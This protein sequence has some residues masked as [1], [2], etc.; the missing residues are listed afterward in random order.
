MAT[1]NAVGKVSMVAKKALDDGGTRYTIKVQ[2]GVEWT[3]FLDDRQLDDLGAELP[4]RG[5]ALEVEGTANIRVNDY[6]LNCVL[7]DLTVFEPVEFVRKRTGE[8]M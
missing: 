2:D 3:L 5:E 4:K 1:V 7:S 6:G 8:T